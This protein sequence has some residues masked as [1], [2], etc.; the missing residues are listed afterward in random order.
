M[1]RHSPPQEDEAVVSASEDGDD[2]NEIDFSAVTVHPGIISQPHETSSLLRQKNGHVEPSLAYGSM[3][4]AR[5]LESLRSAPTQHFKYLRDTVVDWRRRSER[6]FKVLAAPKTWDKR[7]IWRYGVVTPAAYLP[8]VLL[9]LLL[10]ILDALS[11]GTSTL[12]K[13][14]NDS[15]AQ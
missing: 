9:G 4:F 10:N 12:L 3:P 11:Y 5:D 14:F 2:D 1:L 15:N 6:G 13:A 8:A 7:A